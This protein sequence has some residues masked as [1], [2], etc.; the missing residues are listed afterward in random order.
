MSNKLGLI[1]EA[2]GEASTLFMT[3]DSRGTDIIMP[4]EELEQ[5]AERLALRLDAYHTDA[6]MKLIGPIH[7][8]GCSATDNNRLE[9]LKALTNLAEELIAEVYEVMAYNHAHYEN[10]RL[11]AADHCQKFF[12]R[13]GDYEPLPS[14]TQ[15]GS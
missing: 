9:N 12:K 2:L 3:Q 6:V 10:S 4:T 1:R 7:P 14:Q 8:I 5:V 15:E 11:I 13:I